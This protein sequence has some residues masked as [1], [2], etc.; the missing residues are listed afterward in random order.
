MRTLNTVLVLVFVSLPS[1]F[2]VAEEQP[3]AVSE[4]LALDDLLETVSR[5]SGE[6]F[7]RHVNVRP[8]VVAGPMRKRDVTLDSLHTILRNNGLAAVSTGNVVSIVPVSVVRQ[9][10]LRFVDNDDDVIPEDEWVTRIV[11]PQR[12][13]ANTLVAVLRPLVPQSGHLFA[14]NESNMLTIVAPY[15]VTAHL[16]DIVAAIDTATPIPVD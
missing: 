5:K 13:Y 8:D 12:A 14:D 11:R 2:V 10:P 3:P 15:G 7:L 9:H 1:A 6:R 4:K 16:A